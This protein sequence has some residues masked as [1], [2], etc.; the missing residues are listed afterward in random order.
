MYSSKLEQ[1]EGDV[2]EIILEVLEK[3]KKDGIENLSPEILTVGD[4]KRKNALTILKEKLGIKGIS[5][6]FEELR[7]DIYC[8]TSPLDS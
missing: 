8:Q 6:L 7:K 4:M 2:R 5:R 1:F 3:Y